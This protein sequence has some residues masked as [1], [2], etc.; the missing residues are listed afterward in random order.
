MSVYTV[1][2]AWTPAAAAASA[3]LTRAESGGSRRARPAE[4][5]GRGVHAAPP[6]PPAEVQ[7]LEPAEHDPPGLGLLFHGDRVLQ[8]QDQ[9]V[10]RERERLGDHLLVPARDEVERAPW[11]T[12]AGGAGTR[13]RIMA[14]RRQR[15]TISPRW[16]LARCSKITIP[17]WGRERDSR[18]SITSVSA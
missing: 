2:M 15:M 1:S 16:F 4:A 5:G 13:R 12:H 6:L 18:F 10:G 17:H 7:R 3:G 8:V 14:A 9:R 11:P